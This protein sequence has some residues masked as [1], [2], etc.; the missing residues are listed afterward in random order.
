MMPVDG[1]HH[2]DRYFFLI[3]VW[4]KPRRELYVCVVITY[5]KNR[6]QRGKAANSA[7]GQLNREN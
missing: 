5:S 7:H 1:S 2:D 3:M 6:D 4:Y